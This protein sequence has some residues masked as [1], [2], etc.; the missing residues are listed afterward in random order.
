MAGLISLILSW[1]GGFSWGG[2][3]LWMGIIFLSVLIHE[4]GHAFTAIGFGQ[5]AHV[6]LTPFGG[7]TIPSGSKLSRGKEF[8]V[9]LAGPLFGL[10]VFGICVLILQFPIQHAA[11][12]VF[13][14]QVKYVNLFWTVV[15]LLPILPLD[16]GQLMRNVLEH[17]FGFQAFRLSL[18]CSMGFAILLG[19]LSFV[20]LK[21][22]LL[23]AIFFFFAFQ[24]FDA[25]R[26]LKGMKPMDQDA[27]IHQELQNIE[28]F[29]MNIL[30]AI[31]ET[32]L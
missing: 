11:V 20:L 9:I 17:F 28:N 31:F 30:V 5:R 25:H 15:N 1:S 2:F 23:A 27:N 29:F 10:S 18:L 7:V 4:L 16:G 3:L 12:L 26:R 22:I 13:L 24:S 14:Q 6:E 8:L 19:V 21:N 32:E